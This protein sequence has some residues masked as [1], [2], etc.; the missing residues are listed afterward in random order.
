MGEVKPLKL[1]TAG[2]GKVCALNSTTAGSAQALSS[3]KAQFASLVR[4]R[5]ASRAG[6]FSTGTLFHHPKDSRTGS[7]YSMSKST[8]SLYRTGSQALKVVNTALITG[9]SPCSQGWPSPP[10]GLLRC[11]RDGAVMELEQGLSPSDLQGLSKSPILSHPWKVRKS[12][13]FRENNGADLHVCPL[14]RDRVGDPACSE[15]QGQCREPW[16]GHTSLL[17]PTVARIFF[18]AGRLTRCTRLSYLFPEPQTLTAGEGE[19]EQLW[20]CPPCP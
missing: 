8:L 7:H 18:L 9:L 15:L 4:R 3:D 1:F 2:R 14:C 13:F 10:G 11:I 6:V 17:G 19:Q 12:L 20:A 16:M 5:A